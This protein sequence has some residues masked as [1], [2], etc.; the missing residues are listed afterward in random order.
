[1]K[2]RTRPRSDSFGTPDEW[3][4]N[5]QADVV[6]AFFGFNESFKGAEGLREIPGRP[7]Q[8]HRG[9][10]AR[11]TTAARARRASSCFR[12]SRRRST[13]TRTSPILRPVNRQLEPYVKAMR[14]VAAANNVPFVD[15]FAPSQKAYSAAKKSLTINGIHLS[16]E[17]YKAI[18]PAMFAS[19]F[20]E[21]APA[22]DEHGF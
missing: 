21:S 3:L 6:F 11:R 15:L 1:M 19:V 18:A 12:P 2:S 16:D 17:G 22:D 7:R 8:V 10:V 20:G 14:E 5:V 9:H 4:T 13:A